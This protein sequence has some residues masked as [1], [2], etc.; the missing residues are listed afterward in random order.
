MFV[1]R[2]RH[3]LLQNAGDRVAAK[4]AITLAPLQPL[5]PPIRM[6]A[7]SAGS[8]QPVALGLLHLADVSNPRTPSPH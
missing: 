4:C 5:P 8:S 3:L 7:V 2:L 1:N 6:L